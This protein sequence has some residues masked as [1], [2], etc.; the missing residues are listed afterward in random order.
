MESLIFLS[1]YQYDFSRSLNQSLSLKF[2]QGSHKIIVCLIH[3]ASEA[4]PSFTSRTCYLAFR[5]SRKYTIIPCCFRWLLIHASCTSAACCR[6][7]KSQLSF[8]SHTNDPAVTINRHE[9]PLR[10]E[11]LQVLLPTVDHQLLECCLVRIG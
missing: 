6:S 9:W 1:L 8:Y 3:Y 2:H 10:V 7:H 11:A 5:L 4:F